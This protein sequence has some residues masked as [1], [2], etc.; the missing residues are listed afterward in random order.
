MKNVFIFLLLGFLLFFA[1]S[2][3]G[4]A[5]EAAAGGEKVYRIYDLSYLLKFPAFSDTEFGLTDYYG[6]SIA[7]RDDET[8]YEDSEL[9]YAI[10]ERINKVIGKNKK[11]D[12]PTVDELVDGRIMVY[13]Y[14]KDLGK[15]VKLMNTLKPVKSGYDARMFLLSGKNVK[16]DG[17][18]KSSYSDNK[19]AV[20]EAI[21]NGYVPV[22]DTV[23]SLTPGRQTYIENAKEVSYIA[24]Y[25]GLIAMFGKL[26]DP[27]IRV[28]C[29]GTSISV[30]LR[31]KTEGVCLDLK[32][33]NCVLKEI[34]S[35]QTQGYLLEEPSCGEH[36]TR[37]QITF[38]DSKVKCLR[39]SCA[40]EQYLLLIS[41]K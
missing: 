37:K 16:D 8:L 31:E 36:R 33:Q 25:E 21:R 18:G 23:A 28:F 22:F 40:G 30:T 41:V 19:T 3:I 4:T 34:K 17:F 26:L 35:K 6:I 39:F 27:V 38:T 12:S 20:E 10:I 9:F 7:E 29:A 5:E 11:D 15:V 1:F 32:L 2:G 13:C 14:E 24:D